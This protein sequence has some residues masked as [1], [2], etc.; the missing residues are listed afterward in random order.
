MAARK[1]APATKPNYTCKDCAHSTDW[2]NKG[3]DGDPIFCRCKFH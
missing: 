3:A 1:T 2:H